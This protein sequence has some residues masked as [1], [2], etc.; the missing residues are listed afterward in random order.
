MENKKE[1]L[2]LLNEKKYNIA[3]QI[4]NQKIMIEAKEKEDD[5]PFSYKISL[6]LDEFK[7]RINLF[8]NLEEVKVFLDNILTKKE[9]IK[10]DIDED[11]ENMVLIVDYTFVSLKK[12]IKFNLNRTILSDKKMIEYL[13]KQNKILKNIIKSYEK[14]MLIRKVN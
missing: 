9:N 8:D 6:T 12:N 11:E 10:A 2:F 3:F 5:I 4:E 14:K 7:K 13:I 1:Y